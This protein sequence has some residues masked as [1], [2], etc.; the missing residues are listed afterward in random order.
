MRT[1]SSCD[2]AGSI[3]RDMATVDLVVLLFAYVEVE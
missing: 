1:S 2:K 3:G